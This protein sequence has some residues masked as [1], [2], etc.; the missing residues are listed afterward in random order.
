MA[1]LKFEDSI[2]DKLE[3]RTI[4]PSSGS[5]DKLEEQLGQKKA[6][7]RQWL[8]LAASIVGFLVITT[9]F[10]T[11]NK[12]VKSS[13]VELVDID[14]EIIK[15]DK[16]T[17]FVE[18]ST[19]KSKS[20]IKKIRDTEEDLALPVVIA[21]NDKKENDKKENNKLRNSIAKENIQADNNRT[22]IQEDVFKENAIEAIA[23][24]AETIENE[25]V[26]EDKLLR[27]TT[28]VID[29]KIASVIEKVKELERNKGIVTD[30]E[31]EALLRN[32]QL[33]ITTQ[34][35]LKSNSVSASALL[36]DVESELDESFKD[37]VFEALKTGFEK[38]KTTVAERDN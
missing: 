25:I 12:D 26:K 29:S 35:I 13:D 38:L 8:A 16:S 14:K 6:K 23:V 11:N 32:A 4:Q 20:E 15:E 34:Q 33:E 19:E 36:L 17:D 9:V 24:Q 37:R 28:E 5:W 21:K 1:P 22:N 2:K 18:I 10:I 30:A 31:V 7:N 27:V 3:Q